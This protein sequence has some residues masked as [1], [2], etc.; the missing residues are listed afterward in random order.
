MFHFLDLVSASEDN[1]TLFWISFSKL[2]I[3]AG[4][5]FLF[6]RKN[7]WRK[8][9]NLFFQWSL[10]ACR[11]IGVSPSIFQPFNLH[12]VMKLNGKAFS[13]V[14]LDDLE[15]RLAPVYLIFLEMLAFLNRIDHLTLSFQISLKKEVIILFH[16]QLLSR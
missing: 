15:R 5:T 2:P 1:S 14:I 4:K 8:G 10:L 12:E 11:Q 6:R 3:Q 7:V 9:Q 16:I 13:R